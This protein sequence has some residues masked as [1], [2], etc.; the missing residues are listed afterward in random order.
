M[1]MLPDLGSATNTQTFEVQITAFRGR[2][3]VRNLITVSLHLGENAAG[4]WPPRLASEPPERLSIQFLVR[5]KTVV[6]KRSE[7]LDG[8]TPALSTGKL[9]KANGSDYGN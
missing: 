1:A 6:A 3:R 9:Q 8:I 7:T 5:S 2:F 4:K